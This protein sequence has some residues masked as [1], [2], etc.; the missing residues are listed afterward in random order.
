MRMATVWISGNKLWKLSERVAVCGLLL[1]LMSMKTRRF[2][3]CVLQDS[4]RELGVSLRCEADAEG[5]RSERP[6]AV[7]IDAGAGAIE[8]AAMDECAERA[9]DGGLGNASAV[10]YVG[11]AKLLAGA[12]KRLEDFTGTEDGLRLIAVGALAGGDGGEGFFLLCCGVS[13]VLPG[14]IQRCWPPTP[15]HRSFR[16]PG[17]PTAVVLMSRS[18]VPE[19]PELFGSSNILMI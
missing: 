10:N 18:S 3:L 15:L 12:A 2:S 17:Y 5:P 13:G 19:S 1:W 6:E 16:Y 11:E 9:K 7:A 8:Q 4:V 14:S